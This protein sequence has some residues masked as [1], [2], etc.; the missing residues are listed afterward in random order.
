MDQSNGLVADKILFK[1]H[2][3]N[4]SSS[5]EAITARDMG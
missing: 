3:D 1:T 2:T 5:A 4:D